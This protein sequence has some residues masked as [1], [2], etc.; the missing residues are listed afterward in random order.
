[1]TEDYDHSVTWEELQGLN[2]GL[3][4]DYSGF[5]PREVRTKVLNVEPFDPNNIRRYVLRP[6]D[7]R[8]CYYSSISPLWN[9]SRP[10]LWTQQ[11]EGNSFLVSRVHASKEPEGAP[12]YFSRGLVDDHLLSPDASCFPLRLRDSLMDD[13]SSPDAPTRANLSERAREYLHSLGIKNPDADETVASLIWLHALAVGFSPA[14]LT[15]NEDG[16]RQDWPRVPLPQALDRLRASAD[17]GRQVAA[18]LDTDRAIPG[19]TSGNIRPELRGV[20]LIRHEGGGAL[21]PESGDLALTSGW[22]R[23]DRRGI[24]YPSQGEMVDRDYTLEERNAIEE[25][26]AS[27]GLTEQEAFGR[28]GHSTHDVYLNENACWANIPAEVLNYTIGGFPAVRKWLSYR[29]A[30][31]L[32]RSMT[33]DEV[34][35]VRTMVRRITAL[36]LLEERLDE[37]Y[38]AVRESLYAWP[39]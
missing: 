33:E 19:I 27:L 28:I 37:N 26:A 4:K 8:W 23:Q 22:G 31:I 9:R 29:E 30:S 24:V 38:D 34:R 32:G 3:T 15:D 17:L 16:V 18:L 11:W 35:E 39:T 12:F 6:F 36:L 21:R 7:A 10:V 13:S 1:M 25:G 5:Q 14:Y 20:G 2:T